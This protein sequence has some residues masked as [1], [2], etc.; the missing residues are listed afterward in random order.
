M[1]GVGQEEAVRALGVSTL[2]G[3]ALLAL[4]MYYVPC[5][6]TLATIYGE[7][8]S[9]RMTALITAYVVLLALAVSAAVYWAPALVARPGPR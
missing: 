9:W 3:I 4:F 5:M 8:R 1:S 2:Q 7:T 6:A